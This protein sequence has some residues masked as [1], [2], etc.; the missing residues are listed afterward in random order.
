MLVE[1]NFWVRLTPDGGIAAC[2]ILKGRQIPG[3]PGDR[4]HRQREKDVAFVRRASY[5]YG[6]IT[7]RLGDSVVQKSRP[8]LRYKIAF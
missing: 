1:N 2:A 8:I 7:L 6:Y 3:D 5:R 4:H